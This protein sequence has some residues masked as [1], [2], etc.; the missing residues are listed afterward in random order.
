[1]QANVVLVVKVVDT[2]HGIIAGPVG[3]VLAA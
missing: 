2:V 3:I 1:M